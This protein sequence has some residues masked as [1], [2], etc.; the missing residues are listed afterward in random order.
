MSAAASRVLIV[1]DNPDCADLF[2]IQLDREGYDACAAYSAEEGLL[3][4]TVHRPQIA[5]LNT[6]LSGMDGFELIAALCKR[7][8]LE[9]CRFIAVT[10][11][12][13]E[14]FVQRSQAAGF[15]T[16]LIKPVEIAALLRTV[17]NHAPAAG[18][19]SAGR[20]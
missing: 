8:E 13:G 17:A 5:I 4:A 19:R 18:I 3:L 10:C 9:R 11:Y 15:A 12:E 14:S 2:R 7:P 20:R 1:D 16:Y 6:A